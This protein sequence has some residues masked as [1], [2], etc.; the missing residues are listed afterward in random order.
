M[1]GLCF[2]F[3]FSNN[4]QNLDPNAEVDKHGQ[5][6]ANPESHASI[7]KSYHK[8]PQRKLPLKA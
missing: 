2:I 5:N 7:L 8:D 1:K 3:F 4:H 6:W